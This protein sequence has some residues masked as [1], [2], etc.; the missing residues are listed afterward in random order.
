MIPPFDFL[1]GEG[2]EAAKLTSIVSPM[3]RISTLVRPA[4]IVGIL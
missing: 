3:K 4:F 1:H 2:C